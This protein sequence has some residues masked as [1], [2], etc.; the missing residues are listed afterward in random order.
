MTDAS[1]SVVA[2]IALAIGAISLVTTVVIFRRQ[3]DSSRD[4]ALDRKTADYV[5]QLEMRVGDLEKQNEKLERIQREQGIELKDCQRAR[6]ELTEQNFRL[7]L[8][9]DELEAA[10]KRGA[11]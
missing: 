4:A 9:I 6:G 10:V 8:R 5:D 7:Y 11:M 2:L 1:G 3:T